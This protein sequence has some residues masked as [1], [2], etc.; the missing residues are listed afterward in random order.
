MTSFPAGTLTRGK[1]NSLLHAQ[2][3]LVGAAIVGS[4][5]VQ[6][7]TLMKLPFRSKRQVSFRL[8]TAYWLRL[9]GILFP[10]LLW[11]GRFVQ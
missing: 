8:T 1:A 6:R 2:E 10:A 9:T 4:A 3:E 11:L 5:L 7:C